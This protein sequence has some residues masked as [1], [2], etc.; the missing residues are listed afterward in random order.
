MSSRGWFWFGVALAVAGI[1]SV[2]FA[3]FLWGTE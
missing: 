2:A 1:L 3:A